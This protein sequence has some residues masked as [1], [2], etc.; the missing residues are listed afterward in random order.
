M[1]WL[2]ADN[3]LVAQVAVPEL[4]ACAPH[5]PTVAMGPSL[6]STVPV[7]LLPVTVAANVTDWPNVDGLTDEVRT[8]C[9]VAA[10]GDGGS[11]G[12]G[13]AYAGG[14]GRTDREMGRE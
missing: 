9:E 5:E 1:V 7:G 14:G 2:P 4:S 10:P 6:K 8:V 13:A 3:A 11:S 12:A